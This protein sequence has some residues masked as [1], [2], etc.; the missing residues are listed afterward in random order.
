MCV[1]A[2]VCT[3]EDEMGAKGR[4]GHDQLGQSDLARCVCVCVRARARFRVRACAC[5]CADVYVCACA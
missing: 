3:G 2:S 1:R 4:G 5:M